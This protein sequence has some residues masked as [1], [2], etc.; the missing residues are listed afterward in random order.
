MALTGCALVAF[1]LNSILTRLALGRAEIDAATFTLLR[2]ASGALVLALVG[3]VQA[4]SFAW[5]RG[6][7]SGPLALLAYVAPF[8]LLTCALALPWARWFCSAWCN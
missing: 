6:G 7:V 5:L 1:A 3:R 4:G 8:R 2:L